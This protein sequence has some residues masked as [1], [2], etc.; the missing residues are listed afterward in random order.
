MNAELK[1]LELRKQLLVTR[2]ALQRLQVLVEVG[3]LREKTR[4]VESIARWAGIAYML[5]R[6]FRR[7]R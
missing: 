6:L 2:A 3:R 1:E 5:V 7:K 4:W